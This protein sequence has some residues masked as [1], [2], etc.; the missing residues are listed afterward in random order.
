MRTST[1]RLFTKYMLCLSLPRGLWTMRSVRGM[2]RRGGFR[3]KNCGPF[4][5]AAL[6][7]SAT[8]RSTQSSTRPCDPAPSSSPRRESSRSSIPSQRGART[9]TTHS[10]VKDPLLT[11]TSLR[12]WLM[13]CSWRQ[14]SLMSM[15]TKVIFGLWA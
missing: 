2:F 7:D 11:Y 4:W 3:R 12:N 8:S 15:H 10:S 6:L 1:V 13:L 9:T 5:P 14:G